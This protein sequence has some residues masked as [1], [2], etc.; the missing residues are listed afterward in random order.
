MQVAARG[1]NPRNG[2]KTDGAHPPIHPLKFATPNELVG[3]EWSLYEFIVRH[4]LA[5]LSFDA[6]GQE[7][8][9]QVVWDIII[10]HS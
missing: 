3:L 6:N 8:K 5:C 9:V 2:S 10:L 1:L 7:T 4:F